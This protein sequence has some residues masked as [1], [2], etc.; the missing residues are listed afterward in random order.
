MDAAERRAI[1]ARLRP[2]VA[3]MQAALRL[4]HWRLDVLDEPAGE[5]CNADVTWW[6][7]KYRAELRFDDRCLASSPAEQRYSIVHELIH[8]H[9]RGLAMVKEGL[10]LPLGSAVFGEV[11]RRFEHE[12]ELAVDALASLVAPLLPP[13]PTETKEEPDAVR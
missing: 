6:E 10:R 9:L 13:P 1:I 4:G 2:Y 5:H 12:E 7:S 3:E 8:L 11:D